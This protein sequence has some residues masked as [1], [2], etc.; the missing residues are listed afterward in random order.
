[1]NCGGKN[2]GDR[3]D[4]AAA[5]VAIGSEVVSSRCC[6]GR[7][8]RTN[9]GNKAAVVA[10][11]DAPVL[12]CGDRDVAVATD[13]SSGG[14]VVE[15]NTIVRCSC[16]GGCCCRISCGGKNC[17]DRNDDAAVVATGIGSVV[18]YC[19]DKDAVAAVV[20]TGSGGG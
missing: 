1:M 9:W 2:C 15:R 3:N 20:A 5:V 4:A 16:C 13:S 8:S 10:A 12:Y 7:S 6:G 18:I 17:G 19:G 11:G 14:V